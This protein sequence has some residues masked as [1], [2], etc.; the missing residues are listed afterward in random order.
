MLKR[1]LEWRRQGLKQGGLGM[2]IASMQR[3]VE[4]GG[5][6]TEV[7]LSRRK[8][9]PASMPASIASSPKLIVRL[10]AGTG[11]LETAEQRDEQKISFIYGNLPTGSTITREQVAKQVTR[12]KAV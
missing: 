5:D 3:V 8:I 4:D 2:E 10:M 1:M 11:L 9:A 12:L 7:T 6:P